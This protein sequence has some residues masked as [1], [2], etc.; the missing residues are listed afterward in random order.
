MSLAF[1]ILFTIVTLNAVASGAVAWRRGDP[2]GFREFI[3]ALIVG[4]LFSGGMWR[5]VFL[6]A[7]AI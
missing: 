6:G 1:A 2:G 5:Y 3:F 7:P 4:G